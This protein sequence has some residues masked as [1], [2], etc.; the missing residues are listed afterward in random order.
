MRRLLRV[1]AGV[2]P[3]A[4]ALPVFGV[5]C[6]TQSQM[7]QA[8]R[9]ALEQ[10]ARLLATNVQAGNVSAVREQTIAAVGAQFGGIATSI[11]SVDASI[12]RAAIT[13]NTIY[14]LD[15][16][17]LKSPADT[18]FFCG[19]AGSPLTVVV[20]IPNLPPG[21]YA[22]AIVH[23]TGV[24]NPQ[25]LTMVLSNDPVGSSS[26]KLAGFF[27]KPM[28]VAGHDGLWFWQ[29]ARQ[30][31]ARKQ[32]WGAW[33]Y[34]QTALLLLQ[35]VDFITSPNLQKLN[36]EADQARPDTLPGTEPMRITFN[37]QVLNVTQ[38]HTGEFGG[39]LDLIVDYEGTPTPDPVAARAQVTAVMRTLLEQHPELH[40]AFHGIWVHASAPNRPNWFALELPMEQI[41]ASFP[42][43]EQLKKRG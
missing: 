18:Q 15:A 22:L 21:R 7:N 31:A 26:W 6:T 16:T 10:A 20:S 14:L 8:Q 36:K 23:A 38:V 27:V 24:K 43:P 29:Q 41:E 19:I 39:Q 2:L 5:N 25:Q 40:D 4:V 37:G 11:Q 12:Q 42:A 3:L 35:P 34:Y 1:L 13:V 17:D 9:T 28:T 33:L 32:Q 30:Y